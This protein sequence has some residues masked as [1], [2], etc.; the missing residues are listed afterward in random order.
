M[1]TGEKPVTAILGG[2]KVS[3]KITIIDNILDKN[4]QALPHAYTVVRAA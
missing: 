1:T 4:E 3:S 2:A